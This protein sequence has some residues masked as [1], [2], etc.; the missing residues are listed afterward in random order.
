MTTCLEEFPSLRNKLE[1]LQKEKKVLTS[2]NN[3]LKIKIESI[4]LYPLD[5]SFMPEQSETYQEIFITE[6]KKECDESKQTV[7]KYKQDLAEALIQVEKLKKDNSKLRKTLKR[8]RVMVLNS[9]QV[10]DRVN[11]STE[12]ESEVREATRESKFKV[13]KISLNLKS[14]NREDLKESF[15]S[16]QKVSFENSRFNAM[17]SDDSKEN[18]EDTPFRTSSLKFA[19]KTSEKIVNRSSSLDLTEGQMYILNSFDN[20]FTQYEPIN[21][22]KDLF[23]VTRKVISVMVDCDNIHI[24]LFNQELESAYKSEDKKLSKNAALKSHKMIPRD[25]LIKILFKGL[26]LTTYDAY[27]TVSKGFRKSGKVAQCVFHPYHKKIHLSKGNKGV[28]CIIMCERYQDEKLSLKG[29]FGLRDSNILKLICKYLSQK[30]LALLTKFEAKNTLQRSLGILD[31]FK[32]LTHETNLAT[33]FQHITT[34]IPKVFN[35]D[36]CGLFFV[37]KDVKCIYTAEFVGNEGDGHDYFRNILKYPIGLGFT[38]QSIERRK[39]LVYYRVESI[40]SGS[41]NKS[42]IS[43]EEF[44]A[45]VDNSISQEKLKNGLYGPLYDNEG[46]LQGAIQ[47]LNKENGNGTFTEEEIEEFKFLSTILAIVISK[48]YST[49]EAFNPHIDGQALQMYKCV[50]NLFKILTSDLLPLFATMES[51]VEKNI[52]RISKLMSKIINAKRVE[53]FRSNYLMN[54]L[55][56]ELLKAKRNV[57]GKAIE[58]IDQPSFENSENSD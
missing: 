51:G 1:S 44:V 55:F 56:E 46:N 49:S 54:E 4:N 11:I 24:A 19:R 50:K 25:D 35:C 30:I 28:F 47:L 32:N 14:K 36:S 16:R 58:D 42:T 53:A 17:F 34:S 18:E 43:P 57:G 41:E 37:G 48:Q 8:Y 12:K 29:P 15:L 6:L 45:E 9:S 2:S 7:L 21:N 3:N 5:K 33:I 39:P 20:I 26:H 52:A 38:G 31:T 22:L 23:T 27:E 10:K 13:N 40:H